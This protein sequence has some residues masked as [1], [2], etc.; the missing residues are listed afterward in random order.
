MT[1]SQIIY[2]KLIEYGVNSVN[3]YSGGA[4]MDLVDKF[5]T[6]NH[7][8]D[9]D[10]KK[11]EPIN[12]YVHTHE[13]S[14]GHASTGYAKATGK[15]G[16]SIVTSGPGLTNMITPMLDSTND[17]TP[18]LVI[19]G[20][21]GTS[22]IGTNA[23]Q[24]CDAVNLSSSATKFSYCVKDVEYIPIIMDAAFYI[25]NHKK[26]G[27]V[28]IDL[29]KN[30]SSAI[31]QHTNINQHNIFIKKYYENE[32]GDIVDM[33]YYDSHKELCHVELNAIAKRIN[34]AKKPVL[35][36]GQGCNNYSKLLTNF[37]KKTN[38]PVTTTL[39][40]MGVFDENDPLSLEMLGMH[41][42]AY[43]NYAI[44]E[45][46]LIICLGARFDDRTTGNLERYAP[47][48]RKKTNGKNGIIHVN[49]NDNE[50]N[51]VVKSDFAVN[52]DCGKFLE[53]IIPLVEESNKRSNWFEQIN[54]WKKKHPISF[55]ESS[56]GKIKTQSV[57]VH[58]NN[59]LDPDAIVTTGV[60]SHQMMAAQFIKWKTP[61]KI[62]SS[63]SLGVMG[64][65]VPYAIG[66]QIGFP[67]RQVVVIDGDS[68]FLM[69]LNELKTI[70][71]YNLP[72]KIALMNNHTQGMV[73]E[74]ENL[75]FD[76]RITATSNKNNPKFAKMAETFGI[77]SYYCNN[78]NNVKSITEEFLSY[79]GPALCE[80]DTIDEICLPLV[81]PGCG[82]DEMLLEDEYI[83]DFDNKNAEP[84]S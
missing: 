61:M 83:T 32:Y 44:Q 79:P 67:N 34:T 22:A 29:P 16:V 84:P 75:F 38:I 8:N 3:L 26:K 35:Y 20:Q 1:G 49:I 6:D 9:K 74:W 12:Y 21:V 52:A 53:N 41:G 47:N 78:Q 48:A 45:S 81:K 40:A 55:K 62:L 14:V 72:I 46:D 7:H 54:E 73:K 64:V 23:F 28:H 50:L 5:H 37:A 70:V 30:I 69:T 82:L 31:Y 33:E 18:L 65:G 4:I 51:F 27:A 66:A 24:E 10:L 80:Y 2:R 77:K 71:E 57:L 58:I 56:D 68:S 63:G 19:S 36:V 76:G 11:I 60:G 43:A 13:Q 42:T 17:S 25:A 39:H 15:I 59:T